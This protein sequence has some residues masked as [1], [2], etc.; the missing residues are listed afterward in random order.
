M[1]ATETKVEKNWVAS[2]RGITPVDSNRGINSQNQFRIYQSGS[3]HIDVSIAPSPSGES[4]I[5][6]QASITYW[7]PNFKKPLSL[8]DN[9]DALARDWYKATRK[10][11][12]VEQIVLHPS[13]QKIIGMGIE[14][15]PFIF[16][17][18]RKTRGHWLWALN[19]IVGHDRAKSGQNFRQAVDS[20]LEWGEKEGYLKCPP[21]TY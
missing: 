1:P 18:L 20:W 12:N 4:N 2:E 9:F 14:A 16:Q 3:Y 5:E 21:R 19:M 15:L 7:I 10:L 6:L 11:S 17:E 8:K 13:Y